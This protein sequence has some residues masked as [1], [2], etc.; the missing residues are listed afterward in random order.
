MQNPN[1]IETTATAAAEHHH[2]QQC[3]DEY[4]SELNANK[5]VDY[6]SFLLSIIHFLHCH[7]EHWAGSQPSHKI[8]STQFWTLR[9]FWVCAQQNGD[10]RFNIYFQLRKSETRAIAAYSRLFIFSL[11]FLLSISHYTVRWIGVWRRRTTHIR[12]AS[13]FSL[14]KNQMANRMTSYHSLFESWKSTKDFHVCS[15]HHLLVDPW[16]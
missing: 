6:I 14:R 15:A 4:I 13:R 5:R 12:F 8:S 2:C 16:P 3:I 7:L 11:V 1:T 10:L 9:I